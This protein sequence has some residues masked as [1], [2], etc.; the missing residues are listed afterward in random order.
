MGKASQI[1]QQNP[2]FKQSKMYELSTEPLIEY[3]KRVLKS[4]ETETLY[5]CQSAGMYWY[6]ITYAS[7]ER[8]NREY[9]Y[10]AILKIW[11]AIQLTKL[12]TA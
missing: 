3:H 4:T 11:D 8:I 7:H 6:E 10:S 9:R 1:S 12:Q 5:E 2:N